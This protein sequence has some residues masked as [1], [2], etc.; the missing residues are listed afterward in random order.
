MLD[1]VAQR[2]L[3]GVVRGVDGDSYEA[4][5]EGV[6]PDELRTLVEQID[7]LIRPYIAPT[8]T[9]AP[10]DSAIAELSLLAFPRPTF[11]A[12]S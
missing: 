10:D 8:R 4:L 6:T 2:V 5:A 9:D 12:S 1:A 11:G 7:A 3:E